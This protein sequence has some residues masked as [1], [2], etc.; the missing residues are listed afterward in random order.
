MSQ[1]DT[2]TEVHNRVAGP[3][4]DRLVEVFVARRDSGETLDID[5]YVADHPDWEP[6]LRARLTQIDSRRSSV[7]N[8][9]T[10][11]VGSSDAID[12]AAPASPVERI[13]GYRLLKQ[14]GRGGMGVVYLAVQESLDRTVAIKLIRGG[15]GSEAVQRFEQE[16]KAAACLSH[17]NIVAVHEFGQHGAAPYLSMEFVAG[18]SLAEITAERP[19]PARE[20]ATYM[21]AI[22]DAIQCAHDSRIL[23]RDIKPSNILID[24]HKQPKVTDFG[25]AK[26]LEQPADLTH[27]GGIVGTP[28]FMSPEQ[29]M[30]DKESETTELSDIYS[31]GATLYSI[32]TGR[33]PHVAATPIDTIRMVIAHDPVAPR[34]L[35]TGIDRDLE[36]VCLKCLAKNPADR[37]SS[38]GE[39]KAD[40]QRY[41]NDE[42]VLA[43]PESR[44]SKARRWARKNPAV[45]AL[46]LAIAAV[47]FI[48]ATGLGIANW[49][50]QQSLALTQLHKTRAEQRFTDLFDVI[51]QQYTLVSEEKLLREPGLTNLRKQLLRKARGYY[52]AFVQARPGDD[53]HI[54]RTAL[55]HFRLGEIARTLDEKKTAASEYAAALEFQQ[56]LY[57]QQEHQPAQDV[58]LI[59]ELSNT[60]NS[61][62]VLR[63][64]SSQLKAAMQAFQQAKKLR[65]VWQKQRAD[66]ASH[67]KLANTLMN[68]GIVERKMKNA[69]RARQLLEQAQAM[70]LA[71]VKLEVKDPDGA[72]ELNLQRDLAKGAYSLYQY[73]VDFEP[74]DTSRAARLQQLQSAGSFQFAVCRRSPLNISEDRYFFVVLMRQLAVEK[75]AAGDTDA[76]AVFMQCRDAIELVARSNPS[77]PAYHAEAGAVCLEQANFHL[78]QQQTEGVAAMLARAAAWL[79]PLQKTN[80]RRYT[81]EFDKIAVTQQRLEKLL[82]TATTPME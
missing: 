75:A 67:R 20:A 55:A 30:L 36:T 7:A 21:A 19:L 28:A 16:A 76:D 32:L 6:Q 27:A 23:H 45:A 1:D 4:L 40:L 14:I 22:A 46:S 9:D 61:I 10:L 12:R 3:L 73:Y 56:R 63:A 82:A 80:D 57:K 62:G 74:A 48:A 8:A 65:E 2:L 17:P 50:L 39:L 52:A 31:L 60:Y 5:T 51:D 15:G 70:R 47:I 53:Q 44:F 78:S 66:I 24:E 43:R 64:S 41:L 58:D 11:S 13:G 34:T 49:R 25:L 77:I 79:S 37:Y 29:A 68:L 59:I 18:A 69:R 71:A 54:R 35:N 42:P 26:F 38:A 81:A 33:A 72:E